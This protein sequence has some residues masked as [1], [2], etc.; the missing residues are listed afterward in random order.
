MRWHKGSN[1]VARRNNASAQLAFLVSSRF[2]DELVAAD[3]P[4]LLSQRQ[5]LRPPRLASYSAISAALWSSSGV[6][7]RSRGTLATPI[8]A[9]IATMR[10][11]NTIG[12]LSF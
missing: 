11:A 12:S 5:V 2:H 9:P 6:M 8:L 10:S 4:E 1:E 3:A 7:A